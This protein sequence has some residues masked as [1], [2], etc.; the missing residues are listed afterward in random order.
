MTAMRSNP[1]KIFIS[2][3]WES[4][5][6]TKWVV[7]L[8]ED[9]QGAGAYVL[10]DRWDVGLGGD[11]PRFMET[12][13]RR[14]DHILLVCTPAYAK[15]A[16]ER[17]GGVGYENVVITGEIFQRFTAAEGRVI[18]VLRSGS[19]DES[20][21]TWTKAMMAADLRDEGKYA[22]GLE[23]ILRHVHAEPAFVRPPLGAKPSF[24]ARAA[25]SDGG[26]SL[27]ALKFVNQGWADSEV[28]LGNQLRVTFS[29]PAVKRIGADLEHISEKKMAMAV[30]AEP[31]CPGL[32]NV[33]AT[34][35][36]AARQVVATCAQVE[37]GAD[38]AVARGA[39]ERLKE[40]LDAFRQMHANAVLGR[41]NKETPLPP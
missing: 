6:H 37:V 29:L 19:W 35:H 4:D 31:L 2:Y 18:P 26:P 33:V 40:A 22:E 41:G 21:P 11:L 27:A 36:T 14:A 9:L 30:I 34:I 1:P 8:A 16:N 7:R 3:A 10:L 20:R 38:I 15:K 39:A 24:A 32:S 28:E 13:V 17:S 23:A 5:D 25:P 12:A